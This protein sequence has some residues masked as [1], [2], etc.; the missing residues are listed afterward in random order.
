MSV[1]DAIIAVVNDELITLKDL[2]DYAQSTYVNLVAQGLSDSQIE[3]EMKDL[4]ERGVNKLIEDKLILSRANTIGI[5]VRGTIIDERVDELI[6]QYGSEQKLIDALVKNGSTVTDL[7]NRILEQLKIQFLIDHEVKSKIFVNPQEVTRYYEDN[8]TRFAKG[9][10]INLESVFIA[11]E[12]DKEEALRK[13]QQ[14]LKEITDGVDFKEIIRKYSN[15]PSVGMIERGQLLPKIE[16]IAFNLEVNEIS[17]PIE[18][19][20][21]IYFFKLIGK[22]PAQIADLEDVKDS[23]YDLLY[24]QKFKS[25]FLTWIEGLKKDAYIEIK[26]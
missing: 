20:T 16:N 11:Y 23:I 21:G 6:E 15:M 3:A 19:D 17:S 8:K 5:E 25:E 2:K 12:P 13:S 9:D 4:D 24:K 18:V 26:Q 7:R 14:A 10:R 1:E 22:S